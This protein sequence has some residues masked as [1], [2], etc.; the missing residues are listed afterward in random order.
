MRS[1]AIAVGI[2]GASGSAYALRLVEQLMEHGR[3]VHLVISNPGRLVI[4]ME[5]GVSLP[6]KPEL[7]R[8]KLLRRFQRHEGE[9]RV[10]GKEDWFAPVASGSNPPTAM[11]ICPCTGGTLGA[12]AAGMSRG[13]IERAAQ[14]CLKENRKLILVVRETPLSDIHLENML[15]LSRARAVIMPAS[16]GFYSRPRNVEDI[17]DFMVARILDQLGIENHLIDRWAE[18]TDG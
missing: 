17:V 16:P 3:E 18:S 13:L 9:L 10:F 6:N 7:I 14:V 12:I 4:K 11:V 8:E 15:R 5:T 2:T 1:R